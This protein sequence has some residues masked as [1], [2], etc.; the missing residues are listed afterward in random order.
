MIS[1][2]PLPFSV[3]GP[4]GPVHSISSFA[5]LLFLSFVAGAILAPRELQRRGLDP[6]VSEWVIV[7]GVFGT[8]IGAKIGYVFEIWDDIW[9][10]TDSVSDTIMHLWLY[11]EG[12]GVKVPGAVG[13]WET[14]FSRGG[15][16]FYGG[17]LASVIFIYVYL[18][19]RR[20]DVLRYADVFF[21]MLALGY[22]IG[23]MGCLVS[24][25]GCYG[26]ASSVNIPLLTMVY[27]SGSAMPSAGVRVWNTPLIEAILSWALFAW[28]MLVGRFRDYRPGFFVAL[29]LIWDGLSR[30]AVEFLRIN[31]AAI[32]VLPHPQIAGTALL[33]HNDWPSNPE[34]YYFENWHWYG[35]TQSQIVGFV[36]FLSGLL[37]MLYGRLYKSTNKEARNLT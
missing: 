29:F 23:R 37:W 27:G 13:L 1:E 19:M 32:P 26:Y 4:F 21:M 5:L 7:L 33:H 14:L 22:G 18:R 34:A 36:L 9:V 20:L 8:F 11:R 2:I 15:L 31:D 6:A 12:M 25:D 35:F 16:V 3:P 30:F 10:V 17:L 24:G 28:M